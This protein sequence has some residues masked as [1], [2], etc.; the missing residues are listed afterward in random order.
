V[1]WSFASYEQQLIE[2]EFLKKATHITSVM[3]VNDVICHIVH[4]LRS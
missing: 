1:N 3:T 4:Q 2:A